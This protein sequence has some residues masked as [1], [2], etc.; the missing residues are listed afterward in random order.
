M[1]VLGYILLAGLIVALASMLSEG[2][3]DA[4]RLD[5][6]RDLFIKRG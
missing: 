4:L 5:C 3:K 6:W 1:T 2:A